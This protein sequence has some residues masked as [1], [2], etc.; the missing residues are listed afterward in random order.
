M[1]P[2]ER[3][4]RRNAINRLKSY[5]LLVGKNASDKKNN[6]KSKTHDQMCKTFCFPSQAPFQEN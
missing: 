1:K 4:I 5:L 2:K 3:R 6:K